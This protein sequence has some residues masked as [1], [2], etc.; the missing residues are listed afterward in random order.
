MCLCAHDFSV[1]SSQE[2]QLYELFKQ[3]HFNREE[4]TK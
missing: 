2:D 1:R 4:L 3:K